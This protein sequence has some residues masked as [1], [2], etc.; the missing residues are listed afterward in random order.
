MLTA[1][2]VS[3][4]P[5]PPVAMRGQTV[6]HTVPVDAEKCTTPRQPRW[7]AAARAVAT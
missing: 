4:V 3:I 6:T 5:E 1:P 7:I 2:I